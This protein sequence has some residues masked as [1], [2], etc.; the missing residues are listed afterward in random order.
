MFYRIP[1]RF[2]GDNS[3]ERRVFNALEN[4][5]PGKNYYAIHSVGLANHKTKR[6]GEADFVLVTDF[7]IF[8]IEVKGGS[9]IR[10]ED[11][12]WEY[13]GADNKT[14]SPFRQAELTVYPIEDLLS[15]SDKKKRNLFVTG[16]GV[17][18]P[19]ITFTESDPEWSPFQLCDQ[20]DFPHN[21]ENYI[22][23]LG[24]DFTERLSTRKGFKIR[25]H[26]T[27]DDMKWAVKKIRPDFAHFSL[28]ELENSREE[29]VRLEEKLSIYL[30]QIVDVDNSRTLLLGTAG[31][32]KTVIIREAI[33]RIGRS[34]KVLLICFNAVLARHFRYLFRK[35]DHVTALHY[36]AIFRDLVM[37]QNKE[38]SASNWSSKNNLSNEHEDKIGSSEYSDDLQG[39]LLSLDE[40][41]LLKK[42]DWIIVDEGQDFLDEGAFS[43]LEF[44]SKGGWEKGKFIIAMDHSIQSEVY[45]ALDTK[46]LRKIEHEADRTFNLNRNYRNPN[47]LARRASKIAG[48]SG[49]KTERN[50]RSPPV[51]HTFSGPPENQ[52]ALL[53]SKIDSLLAKGIKPGDITILTYRRRDK[54]FLYK[55]TGIGKHKLVDL[56]TILNSDSSLFDYL[57]W[58]TVHSFKGLENEYIFLIEGEEIVMDNRY[59]ALLYVAI[60]RA[61]TEFHYFG[62][63][64]NATWQELANA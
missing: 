2:T 63:E 57:T 62:Q 55:V 60:T 47:N 46:L 58:S 37:R 59:K 7:G 15:A 41:D 29:L 43:N 23:G 34:E 22:R 14:D 24:Q 30:D 42:F 13:S 3:G 33:E 5:F 19:D 49:I 18:F 28:N 54:S 11:G 35:K 40:E 16:W 64:Q 52:K 36:N 10:K 21:L 25:K 51:F 6:K 50:F 8:C 61:K 12:L 4:L 9:V 31:T 20:R 27:V 17:I 32:G 48:L 39:L 53:L 26:V 44:L 1:S 45:Q 38:A 56:K